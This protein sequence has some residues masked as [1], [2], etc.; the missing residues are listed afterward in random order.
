[1]EQSQSR[2]R[3]ISF[4][5]QALQAEDQEHTLV[6]I[7]PYLNN[8]VE[9]LQHSFHGPQMPPLVH[10]DFEDLSLEAET[11]MRIGLILNELLTNAFKHAF[12][13]G[14]QG[15][16]HLALQVLGSD[17]LRFSYRDNGVGMPVSEEARSAQPLGLS[18][19]LSLAQL[20]NGKPRFLNEQGLY[21]S[22]EFPH[23]HKV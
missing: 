23:P 14:R 7:R 3:A 11:A 10:S 9:Q 1:L 21:F 2:V 22:M 18:L 8:I 6:P 13:Q 15:E 12:P 20:C 19:I 4:L 17:M 16:I 5:H